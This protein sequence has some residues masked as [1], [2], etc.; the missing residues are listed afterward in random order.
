MLIP[1]KFSQ[2]LTLK[3]QIVYV[4]SLLPSATADEVAM[5]LMELKGTASKDGVADLTHD[6]EQA[7]KKLHE[8]Q[9]LKVVVKEDKRV[10]YLLS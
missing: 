4:L 10:H 2:Q 6:V 5:E 8:E 3:E 9:V 1:Q 7:L